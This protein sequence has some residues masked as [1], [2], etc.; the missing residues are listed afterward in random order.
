M[1]L[2]REKVESFNEQFREADGDLAA[3]V[4]RLRHWHHL[5][6]EDLKQKKYRIPIHVSFGHEAIAVAVSDV[7]GAED[8]LVLTHRNGAYN[9]AR[10]GAPTPVFEEYA[11]R[12]WGVAGGRLGSMNLTNPERGIVYTSS[13]LGNNLS[14][15][16][17]LALAKQTLGRKG[18]VIV[19]M[20]DGSMEEGPFYEGLVLSRSLGLGVM[21][22]VEN[23]DHSLASTI[24]ERRCPIALE[25]MC[26]AFQI[27]FEQL[28][29][30]DVFAYAARLREL[31]ATVE[32]S[33]PVCIEVI[34]TTHNQHAGPTPGWPADPMSVSIE[35]GLTVAQDSSD[36]VFVLRQAMGEGLFHG[37][38]SRILS[39]KW[40]R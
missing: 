22:I 3:R 5:L 16:C 6:N 4:L 26:A 13:I 35:N 15:G 1:R 39:E 2:Q 38:K 37:L 40:S 27:P 20:G 14:V 31:R 28:S 18:I 17:G 9:L 33:L 25:R 19:L 36:P 23:N 24:E 11:L 8:Q 30:N 12:P 7:M 10:A 32:Q 21:L 34:L 29:G